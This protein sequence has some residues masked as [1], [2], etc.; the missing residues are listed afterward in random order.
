MADHAELVAL[1]VGHHHPRDVVGL[2]DVDLVGAQPLQP[3]N[4]RRLMVVRGRGHIEMHPV[5]GRLGFRNRHKHQRQLAGLGG[6]SIG[7]F[8]HHLVGLLQGDRPRQRPRPEP[9]QPGRVGGVNDEMDQT[10]RHRPHGRSSQRLR[11]PATLNRLARYAG[12][13]IRSMQACPSRRPRPGTWPWPACRGLAV[14]AGRV[15]RHPPMGDE[16]AWRFSSR[17]MFGRRSGARPVAGFQA[18]WPG[19][20]PPGRRAPWMTPRCQLRTREASRPG[21]GTQ[22]QATMTAGSLTA[23][24]MGSANMESA[25]VGGPKP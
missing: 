5:L 8:D 4:Q 17:I 19:A 22:P 15:Q 16:S 24:S 14:H 3:S 1:G 9:G 11:Q 21:E 6:V 20:I 2:T 13:G 10:S 7:R 18:P 23:R 12:S 25:A